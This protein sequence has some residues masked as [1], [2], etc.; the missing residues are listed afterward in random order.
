MR[1]QVGEGKC[2]VREGREMRVKKV[3]WWEEVEGMRR[4]GGRVVG[5]GAGRW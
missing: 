5:R 2:G 1:V 3:R 4:R